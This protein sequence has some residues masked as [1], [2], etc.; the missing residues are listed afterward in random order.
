MARIISVS[1]QKGG[2]GKTTTTVNLAASLAAAEKKTLIIDFDPQANATSGVGLAKKGEDYN[3]YQLVLGQIAA[4]QAIHPTN[5]PYLQIVPSTVDLVAAELEL[6]DQEKREYQLRE[7]LSA[8]R[9]KFDYIFIDCPPSL[10]FLTLNALVA[11]H[12]VLV[13]VQCE[14]YALEGLSE[15]IETIR[16]VREHLNPELELE[17]ILLTMFDSRTNLSEQVAAEI[18]SHFADKVFQTII[19]RNV[20]LSEAPSHGKPVL[21]YDYKSKGAISYLE[22]AQEFLSQQLTTTVKKEE[23]LASG[24]A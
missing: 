8:M 13:P 17:G 5:I 11:S 7:S 14:Y 22:L 1:N 9:E 6:I 19:A 3:S 18:R 20:R 24:A 16:R 10:G 21:T 2:V 23:A 12:S 15:L 4:D